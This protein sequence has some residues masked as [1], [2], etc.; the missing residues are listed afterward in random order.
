LNYVLQGAFGF[1]IALG[2]IVADGSFTGNYATH[3]TQQYVS[4]H[5][6][7]REALLLAAE[8][9]QDPRDHAVLAGRAPAG[10]VLRLRKSFT[11]LT[12]PVCA[13]DACSSVGAPLSLGDGLSLTLEVPASGRFTWHVPP[14]TRPFVARAGG[15][16]AW[17]LECVQGDAVVATHSVVVGRGDLARVD[18]CDAGATVRAG[19]N[20]AA[21]LL[22]L[23]G[24]TRRGSRLRVRLVCARSCQIS[25]TLR[26]H[27][28]HAALLPGSA[29]TIAL[30]AARG[31]L[32]VR[33]VD[34]VGERAKSSQILR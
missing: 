19:R 28:V 12:S 34:G 16:E 25:A 11:T 30:P 1:T 6:G 23:L 4:A 20:P 29:R 5:G 13:D 22:R 26:G 7:V 32:T 3:V 17:T 24:T 9:A 21:H 10:R 33:A 15:R 31:R 14:S 2:V 27:S 18:A 8:Q